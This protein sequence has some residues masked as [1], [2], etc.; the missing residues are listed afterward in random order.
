[1]FLVV[2]VRVLFGFRLFRVKIVIEEQ[3]KNLF[4]FL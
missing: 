4:L 1:M 2:V 3:F